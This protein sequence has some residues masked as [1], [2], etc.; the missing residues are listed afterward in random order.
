MIGFYMCNTPVV[1]TT[2]LELMKELFNNE[3]LIARP[4]KLLNLS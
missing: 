4:G 1:V 2:S 3:L